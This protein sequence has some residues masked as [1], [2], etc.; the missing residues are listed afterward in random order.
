MLNREDIARRKRLGLRMCRLRQYEEAWITPRAV[1][2]AGRTRVPCSCAMCGNPRRN[3]KGK[4]RLT[5]QERRSAPFGGL[6]KDGGGVM[7]RP[8]RNSAFPSF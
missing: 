5:I 7:E 6:W 1:G 4:D 2:K 3:R 8:G